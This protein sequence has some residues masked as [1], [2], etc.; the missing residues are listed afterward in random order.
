MCGSAEHPAPAPRH[1]DAVTKEIELAAQNRAFDAEQE[2]ASARENLAALERGLADE[3]E[4]AAGQSAEG[5]QG[6]RQ[7]RQG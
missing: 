3:S 6:R 1:D 2:L 4:R 7:R 5:R